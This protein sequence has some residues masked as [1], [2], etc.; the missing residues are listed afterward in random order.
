MKNKLAKNSLAA[1]LATL[2]VTAGLSFSANGAEPIVA[3]AESS[4][5][6]ATGLTEIIDTDTC[7]AESTGPATEGTGRCGEGL[8]T[9]GVS[10][11]DQT[12][13]TGLEGDQGTSEAAAAVAPIEIDALTTIDLST[14]GEDLDAVN[15]GTIL[16]DVLEGLGPVT[17]PAFE[18]LL[19]PLLE[20]IQNAALTP[21][22]AA[23]QDALPVSI[24]IGAVSSACTLG[25]DGEVDL[26]STVAGIAIVVELPQGG[27]LRVPVNLSTSPN[28]AL[29]GEVAPQELVNGLLDGIEDSLNQSLNGVLGPLAD[30]VGTIQETV[31]NGV[32]DQ[33]GPA[34]LAPVGEALSPILEGTVNEQV[35][36][37]DGSGQVTALSL[38]ILGGDGAAL[39]LARSSCG[40]NS[41]LAADDEDSDAAADADADAAAD[42]DSDA[43]A[44]ADADA[45]AD[46]DADAAADANADAVADADA[47]SDADVT[48]ALPAAG[49]PRNLLPFMFLGLAL[50]LFGGAVLLNEKRRQLT[51]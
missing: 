47:Q 26:A 40:P 14:I 4:A 21:I 27:D 16:D 32:L 7:R 8:S 24:E 6:T 49:A 2:I 28:S 30:L 23:L 46:A 3:Q 51:A 19:T 1:G 33:L 12:A 38:D 18:L 36:N 29:V 22:L 48:Q 37:A 20:Q 44:D 17:G 11:F 15:T 9:Q 43:A 5:V 41:V 35:V 13:S 34:L 45:A 10:A 39:D 31:V 25:A 42:A 50:V